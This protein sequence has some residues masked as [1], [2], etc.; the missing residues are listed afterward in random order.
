MKILDELWY[1][2]V[3]PFE[4]CTRGDKRLKELLKLVA[5]NREDLDGFLTEKQKETLEKFEDCMN[6]MHSI[7]ERN[8]VSYELSSEIRFARDAHHRRPNQREVYRSQDHP[9]RLPHR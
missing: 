6:E 7:A 3:S 8:A 4:Q 1:G 2:N 9:R 5:R